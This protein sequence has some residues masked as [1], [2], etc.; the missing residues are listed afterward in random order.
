MKFTITAYFG[1]NPKMITKLLSCWFIVVV[2]F[3]SNYVLA[4][5][6]TA[7]DP[8]VLKE[9]EEARK[10]LDIDDYEH[11]QLGSKMVNELEKK[12]IDNQ[13]FDQLLYLYLE[14]SYY[15]VCLL[16]TSRCV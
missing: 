16:Y 5:E 8:K 14:I 12:L 11:Y 7:I 13:N 4:Q 1:M 6:Q 10:V 3:T 2:F 15:Y 9:F